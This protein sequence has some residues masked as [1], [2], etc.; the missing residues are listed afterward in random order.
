MHH[1]HPLVGGV[2]RRFRNCDPDIER[3]E[4]A[5]ADS[6]QNAL[7]AKRDDLAM[8]VAAWHRLLREIRAGNRRNGA[9]GREE[10]GVAAM[11]TAE[12]IEW[13]SVGATVC[14]VRVRG[15]KIC[16]Q[17]FTGTKSGLTCLGL[18]RAHF[19]E[20]VERALWDW[21]KITKYPS[22]GVTHHQTFSTLFQGRKNG[23]HA[24]PPSPAIPRRPR[25]ERDLADAACSVST[26]SLN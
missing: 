26:F 23:C 6:I 4:V 2:R 25:W 5:K 13:L 17:G 15:V 7:A 20:P 1:P 19:V 21:M 18:V 8:I 22:P 11:S 16:Q 14:V 3:Q 24:P 9:A 10:T 12:V